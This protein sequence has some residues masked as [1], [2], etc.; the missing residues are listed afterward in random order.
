MNDFRFLQKRADARAYSQRN[1]IPK[2][3]EHN[4]AYDK[5][6]LKCKICDI[7]FEKSPYFT[8]HMRNEH[9]VDKPFECYIC[10]KTYRICSLLAEHIR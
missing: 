3:T 5:K 9:G 8:E 10:T 1:A 4:E 2:K 6:L 7:Q